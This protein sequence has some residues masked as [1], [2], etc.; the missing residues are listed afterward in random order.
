MRLLLSYYPPFFRFVFI[1]QRAFDAHKTICCKT[2]EG[3]MIRLRKK[4]QPIFILMILLTL[5]ISIP[6]RPALA[7]LI[8]SQ[9]FI[10]EQGPDQV[11]CCQIIK[12]TI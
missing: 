4:G 9:T 7:A 10:S 6:F 3:Y 1:Y 12:F 5:S 2:K 8:D 11:R